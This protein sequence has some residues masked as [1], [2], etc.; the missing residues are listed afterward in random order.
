MHS[1][2][3]KMIK[4]NYKYFYYELRKYLLPDK[5]HLALLLYKYVN[6]ITLIFYFII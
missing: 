1:T 4:L 2:Q 6:Q 3:T 5:I